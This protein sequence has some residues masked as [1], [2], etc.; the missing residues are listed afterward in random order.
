MTSKSEGTPN[1]KQNQPVAASEP[2]V[3]SEHDKAVLAKIAQLPDALFSKCEQTVEKGTKT[4]RLQ[5]ESH[6][7]NSVF[8]NQDGQDCRY[9][10][11]DGTTTGAMYLAESPETALKEVFQ[12]KK[13]L[14]ESDLAKYYMGVIVLEKDMKVLQIQAL[15]KASRLTLNDVTTSTRAVTQ[16]L[17]RRVHKAGFDGMY[18]PSNVTGEECLVLWHHKPSGEGVA[19]T[20][21]Q[22][23]LSDYE[24]DGRETADIL[25]DDLGISVE[26]G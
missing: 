4:Y 1:D 5:Y 9:N 3:M 26:E 23:C 17:A 12:N 20:L 7:G 19:T 18:Y 10:L 13:G 22:T 14:K 21:E 11:V 8:F 16:Q 6:G 15:I 2:P 25:V 24:L